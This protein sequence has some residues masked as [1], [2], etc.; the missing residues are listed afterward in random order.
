MK[1]L[2]RPYMTVIIPTRERAQTLRETLKTCIAQD[3]DRLQII[4]SDNCSEDDTAAVVK[5]FSDPRIRYIKTNMRLSMSRNWEFALSHV[6]EGFVTV[7]GDDDGLI[8]GSVT[9]AANVLCRTNQDALAWYKAEYHWPDHPSPLLRN[10]LLV[11]PDNLLIRMK[12]NHVLRDVGRLI[13][14]YNKLPT[15]YNAFVSMQVI[16]SVKRRT[17]QFFNSVTPD[18]YSG[19]ALL[20]VL[21]SYLYSSRPFSINGASGRSNGSTALFSRKV[22]GEMRHFSL[23]ND[24]GQND[25]IQVIPGAVYSSFGE[26]MLQANRYCFDGR[27]T[28]S[29]RRL[30]MLIARD[31]ARLSEERKGDAI[32]EL[33]RMAERLGYKKVIEEYLNSLPLG[34]NTE[35]RPDLKQMGIF[36]RG[37]IM[38]WGNRHGISNVADAAQFVGEL[39]NPYNFPEKA[40][41]YSRWT[42][43]LTE[44]LCDFH[45]MARIEAVRESMAMWIRGLLAK[46]SPLKTG[47]LG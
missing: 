42:L 46:L 12:V 1:E 27:L 31:V 24:M 41:T 13:L 4:V 9:D 21:D 45:M 39:L 19:F 2:A 10:K 40:F 33:L 47:L 44:R 37:Q 15:L 23:E 32:S 43:V 35:L 16:E 5:E 30:F 22:E 38:F 36:E 26:A 28:L 3:Y 34:K 29:L 14:P 25:Q 7:I 6:D 8:P 11:P 17:G 20:S 18:I